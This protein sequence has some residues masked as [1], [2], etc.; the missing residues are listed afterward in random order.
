M[1]DIADLTNQDAI[2]KIKQIAAGEVAMMCTLVGETT[3][4][5]RPMATQT[6]DDDGSVWFMSSGDSAKNLQIA[7]NPLVQLIYSL[8]GKSEFLV[9]QGE[10]TISRDRQKLDEVW[11][12][13]AKNWFPKGKDDPEITL[14]RVKPSAG[15][16]WDTKDGRMV[17]LAKI[18][19]GAITGKT[20]DGGVEGSL[21]V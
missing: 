15:H 2:Q 11:S 12:P 10:A 7:A 17:Q 18:T 19:V 16:Y 8:P 4:N 14:I 13:I 21:R 20:M 1:G 5:T 3:F 6:V 9:V